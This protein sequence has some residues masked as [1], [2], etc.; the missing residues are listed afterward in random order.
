MDSMAY[1]ELVTNFSHG[2]QR[3]MENIELAADGDIEGEEKASAISAACDKLV[4]HERIIDLLK[5]ESKILKEE[6]VKIF[7]YKI[8]SIRKDLERCN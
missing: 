1:K 4:E 8:I 6:F 5:K 7:D 3:I 2:L